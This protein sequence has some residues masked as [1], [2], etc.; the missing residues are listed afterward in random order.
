M[1]KIYEIYSLVYGI[2]LDKNKA[3]KVY[4]N[5]FPA[6]LYVIESKGRNSQEALGLFNVLAGLPSTGAQ[7]LNFSKYYINDP[8]GVEKVAGRP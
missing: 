4:K 3:N 1:K 8:D 7:S 5:I 6:L 2:V